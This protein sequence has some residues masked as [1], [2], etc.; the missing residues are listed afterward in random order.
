MASYVFTSESVSAGHPDKVC[1]QISDALLDAYLTLSPYV[2]VAI[3]SV[4][5]TNRVILVGEVSHLSLISQDKR[6][7]IVRDVI[8]RIGYTQEEFHWRAE[9]D[10]ACAPVRCRC[11]YRRSRDG[12]GEIWCWRCKRR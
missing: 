8:R 5:T 11:A 2:R 9:H 12:L 10:E 7:E 3:E 1:D 4:A 6:E